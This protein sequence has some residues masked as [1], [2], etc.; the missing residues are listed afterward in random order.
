[1]PEA[2]LKDEHRARVESKIEYYP[3]MTAELIAPTFDTIPG[4]RDNRR[5]FTAT[6]VASW[7]WTIVAKKP[8][9]QNPITINI[10]T[11][12]EDQP[13]VL[14]KSTSRNVVVL[15]KPLP[16]RMLNSLDDNWPTILGT[17]GPLGL[18]I[19]YL[20]LRANRASKELKEKVDSLEKKIKALEDAGKTTP[21]ANGKPGLLPKPSDGSD[22]TS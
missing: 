20:T 2:M 10:F 4:D 18:L 14:I 19:A 6:Q 16:T 3:I 13:P 15:D 12:V 21:Q 9:K 1:M 11:I 7:T 22:Q 17:A 8:G 5:A